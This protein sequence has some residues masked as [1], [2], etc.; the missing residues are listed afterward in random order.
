MKVS[1]VAL[2]SLVLGPSTFNSRSA[3]ALLER[4]RK[5]NSDVVQAGSTR[6]E[7]LVAD[8][9]TVTPDGQLLYP[10]EEMSDETAC[11]NED[12]LCDFWA[13]EGECEVN[14][15]YMLV[16]CAKAC[17]SCP[18]HA[19]DL[20]DDDDDDDEY[21]MDDDDDDMD[22]D[23]F[24]DEPSRYGTQS[25]D[26][27]D[28]QAKEMNMLLEQVAKY[29]KPQQAFFPDDDKDFNQ[30][31]VHL[32]IRQTVSYMKNFIHSDRPTHRIDPVMI[33][34][35]KNDHEM[36]SAWASQGECE[37][38]PS[39]MLI[40]CS[41]ACRSCD[42]IH[43]ESRCPPR[44]TE[45]Y[46][47]GLVKGELNLMF[48]RIVDNYYSALPPDAVVQVH[49]RPESETPQPDARGRIH[50]DIAR[51]LKEKPWV[52]TIENFLS[53]Q[54]CDR[55]IELGYEAKYE[56]SQDV[57]GLKPDGTIQA[58]SNNFRTSENA[59]CSRSC[60]EDPTVVDIMTRM[61]NVTRIPSDQYEDFQILK[62]LEGQY[63]RSHH[64][65]IQ[66]Q[67]DRAAGPRILTFFLYLS[68]VEEGGETN[69]P[70]LDNLSIHP[71][72]GRALVRVLG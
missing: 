32:V 2:L 48:Q 15:N 68:D 50:F 26:S 35:C 56:R 38:N 34:L 41:A 43:F 49:S 53:P 67:K 42:K 70:L 65:Y 21:F 14:P 31:L 29:G 24:S 12:E 27:L 8:G 61:Q 9:V 58:S 10:D 11:V 47:P 6:K 20:D 25:K 17:Q 7:S 19:V 66:H 60:R 44:S 57:G 52:I 72:K 45:E 64:D 13:Q 69:F 4:K 22:E 18:G 71:K 3:A 16:H 5:N 39:Y 40:S 59:W 30:S 51:N 36:C 23:V 1:L 62:Y 28:A 37:A 63:Y 55:L 33:N 46:P 54:E